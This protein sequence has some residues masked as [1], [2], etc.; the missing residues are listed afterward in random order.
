MLSFIDRLR[1]KF[2]KLFGTL[3]ANPQKC[4]ANSNKIQIVPKK[5]QRALEI[6]V[7]QF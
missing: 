4:Q 7:F 1:K 5:I 3:L 2:V 6:K